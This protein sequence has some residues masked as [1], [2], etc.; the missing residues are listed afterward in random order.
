MHN[1]QFLNFDLDS[2]EFPECEECLCYSQVAPW[3]TSEFILTRSMVGYSPW[4]H[5]ES[6]RTRHARS[7]ITYAHCTESKTS[8]LDALP[9][10]DTTLD[11]KEPGVHLALL[12]PKIISALSL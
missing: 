8:H 2:L 10:V 12:L 11:L 5:K 7:S 1:K 9:F 4:G 6:D 3:T